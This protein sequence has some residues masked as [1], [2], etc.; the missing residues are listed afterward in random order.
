M[1]G[2]YYLPR[3]LGA[4]IYLGLSSEIVPTPAG[5]PAP[6]PGQHYYKLRLYAEPRM[7]Y[8]RFDVLSGFKH[9]QH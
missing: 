9:E 4:S 1:A 5:Q 3:F 7:V 8:C 2:E 6:G